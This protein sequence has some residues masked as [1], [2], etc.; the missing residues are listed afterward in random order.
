[1]L[2][3]ILIAISTF[4]KQHF[5]VYISINGYIEKTMVQTLKYVKNVT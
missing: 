4:F 1:M 2:G 3:N 5:F